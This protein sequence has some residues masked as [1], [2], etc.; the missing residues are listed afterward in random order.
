MSEKITELETKIKELEERLD[1][2]APPIEVSLEAINIGMW[3]LDETLNK[4]LKA[5]TPKKLVAGNAFEVNIKDK[6]GLFKKTSDA[7][8]FG[9][10]KAEIYAGRVEFAID[11]S[12][13]D[14]L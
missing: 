12:Y 5:I 1:N 8:M 6:S 4:I 10:L 11:E 14:P 13:D 2:F 7:E 3:A 9:L